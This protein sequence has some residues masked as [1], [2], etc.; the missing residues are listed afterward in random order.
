LDVHVCDKCATATAQH[1]LPDVLV[2]HAGGQ[3]T[4]YYEVDPARSVWA[5]TGYGQFGDDLV[6]RILTRGVHP[7]R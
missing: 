6:Q 7:A 5:A 3:D 2:D 1:R 4:P